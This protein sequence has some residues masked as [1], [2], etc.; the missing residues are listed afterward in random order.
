MG[1]G[2]TIAID[3]TRV[4]VREDVR[5]L[6]ELLGLDP[7][8]VANEGRFVAIVPAQEADRALALLR[9]SALAVDARDI[10]EVQPGP[11]GVRAR[12]AVGT[13]RPITMLTG[14]QL[15]RIC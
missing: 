15:P 9:N 12:T 3:E 13:E 5:A 7:L 1:A 8:H 10:G 14:E 6:C 2:V 11:G 4:P